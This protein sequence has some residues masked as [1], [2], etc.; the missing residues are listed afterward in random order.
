M[1]LARPHEVIM[2]D[3]DN[4]VVFS[5]LT[6]CS[7]KV[8]RLNQILRPFFIFLNTHDIHLQ[9]RLVRSQRMLADPISRWSSDPSEYSLNPQVFQR[10]LQAFHPLRPRNK[11]LASTSSALLN[12]FCA[13]WLHHQAALVDVLSCPLQAFTTCLAQLPWTIIGQWPHRVRAHPQMQSLTL[14]PMWASE[15][16]WRLWWPLLMS[17][18]V[19]GTPIIRIR[20]R[21]GLYWSCLGHC[22]RKPDWH[23]ICILLSGT[24]SK[25][26]TSRKFIHVNIQNSWVPSRVIKTLLHCLLLWRC[27]TVSLSIRHWMPLLGFC[28]SCTRTPHHRHVTQI[29]RSC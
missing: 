6:E 4:S 29:Q 11:M 9:V 16:W 5:Y 23:L 27:E 15:L 18:Q 28:W 14:V 19:R 21:W 13:R 3:V 1:S 20:P 7:G 25:R 10:I 2:L 17:L 22:R 12:T 24:A 8:P 26:Q